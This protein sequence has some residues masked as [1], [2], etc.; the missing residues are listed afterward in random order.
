MC[1]DGELNFGTSEPII[2]DTFETLDLLPGAA[3]SFSSSTAICFDPVDV[4]FVTSFNEL[5]YMRPKNVGKTSRHA[6]GFARL[7][8]V[9]DPYFYFLI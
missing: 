9:D 5:M 2:E 1:H 4:T 7:T 3:N 8:I 6:V